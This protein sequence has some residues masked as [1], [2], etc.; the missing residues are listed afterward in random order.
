MA[1]TSYTLNGDTYDAPYLEEKLDDWI[2]TFYTGNRR[3]SYDNTHSLYSNY[4]N[5]L[6]VYAAATKTLK[7]SGDPSYIDHSTKITKLMSVLT[8]K[9]LLIPR[10]NIASIVS[11]LSYIGCISAC[12]GRLDLFIT[13]L[14]D[15]A[16]THNYVA[17]SSLISTYGANFIVLNK[18]ELPADVEPYKTNSTY[19]DILNQVYEK[20]A[21]LMSDLTASR[22]IGSLIETDFFMQE[23][24][25][26]GVEIHRMFLYPCKEHRSIQDIVCMV[27]PKYEPSYEYAV[28]KVL[29]NDSVGGRHGTFRY[30]KEDAKMFDNLSTLLPLASSAYLDYY[31]RIYVE[32]FDFFLHLSDAVSV[33]IFSLCPYAWRQL[34]EEFF[35]RL[36]KS[37]KRFPNALLGH[38]IVSTMDLPIEFFVKNID[39]LYISANY[40]QKQN[41]HAKYKLQD[42]VNLLH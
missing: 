2:S 13:F 26:A 27:Y 1:F 20:M 32:D 6:A 7:D 9:P 30:R 16:T 21:E 42:I 11:S 12:L 25:Q 14:K 36:F 38:P 4:R 28:R 35:V 40:R 8:Q 5:E 17:E 15:I 39:S 33:D 19:D 10:R 18:F 41:Y 24:L 34:D 22:L 31:R 29:G 23:Q 37:N 3:M